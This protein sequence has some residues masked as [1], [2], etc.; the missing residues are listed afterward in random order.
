MKQLT[1]FIHGYVVGLDH[2]SVQLETCSGKGEL[3]KLAFKWNVAHLGGEI[4]EKLKEKWD[5]LPKDAPFF[6]KLKHITGYYRQYSKQKAKE[7]MWEELS[8]RANLEI[9]TAN[10]HN[11]IYNIKK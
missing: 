7:H 5:S 6:S 8:T 3:R 4:R 2:L 9:A 10:L 1:Y 11:D